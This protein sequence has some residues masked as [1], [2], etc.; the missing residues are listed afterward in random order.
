MKKLIL[1]L[2]ALLSV[3]SSFSQDTK[4]VQQGFGYYGSRF[5]N[6]NVIDYKFIQE[7]DVLYSKRVWREIDTRDTANWSMIAPKSMLA[8]IMFSSLMNEELT[9]YEVPD[10]K[11]VD[12]FMKPLKSPE[13]LKRLADSTFVPK[14]DKDGNQIGGS[15]MSQDFDPNSIKKFMIMEDWI[16]NQLTGTFEVRIWGIAP[17]SELKV[18][19]N[20]V[21][22]YVPFWV[23]FPE[24]RYIMATRKVALAD[25]DASNLSYDDWFTRRLFEGTVY[26]VSNPRDLPLSSF[27]EGEALVKAQKQVDNEI[28]EKLAVLTRD[29]YNLVIGDPKK[30]KEKEPKKKKV[31]EPKQKS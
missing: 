8:D 20:I 7:S 5:V 9:A 10:N 14:F 16:F 22:D 26:K 11:K 2:I 6:G 1:I 3:K 31:K 27:Y 18:E 28:Q 19:G 4:P 15:M 25:N 12:Y 29:Y 21:D 24:F 30:G 13:I 23:Y 17:I